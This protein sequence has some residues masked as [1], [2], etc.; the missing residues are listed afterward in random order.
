MS[1]LQTK[2]EYISEIQEVVEVLEKGLAEFEKIPHPN[3]QVLLFHYFA[4][5][6]AK[7]GSASLRILD[8]DH[9]PSER[10]R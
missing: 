1:E 8:L 4:N 10:L 3:T 9:S 6:A 2:E 7:I 5:R